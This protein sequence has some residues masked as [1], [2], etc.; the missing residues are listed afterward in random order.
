MSAIIIHKNQ[1]GIFCNQTYNGTAEIRM[2]A[3]HISGIL[4]LYHGTEYLFIYSITVMVM[5]AFGSGSGLY[6]GQ[7]IVVF[8]YTF[9]LR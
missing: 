9:G 1:L 8:L 3:G 5:L 4:P 6:L 2:R 7:G